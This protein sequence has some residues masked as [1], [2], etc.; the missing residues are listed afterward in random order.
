MKPC[1]VAQHSK[2]ITSH[3]STV[4]L[5]LDNVKLQG[6]SLSKKL[7]LYNFTY[8]TPRKPAPRLNS[9]RYVFRYKNPKNS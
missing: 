6:L 7:L 3:V 5:Q 8:K 4:R 9:L 1:Q 2:C